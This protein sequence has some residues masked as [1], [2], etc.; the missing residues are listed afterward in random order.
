VV[1]HARFGLVVLG[2]RV[3]DVELAHR[4]HGRAAVLEKLEDFG[5]PLGRD[6]HTLLATAGLLAVAGLAGGGLAVLAGR[7]GRGAGEADS[8]L[9]GGQEFLGARE[10]ERG[11]QAL[12]FVRASGFDFGAERIDLSGQ[13]R[14]LRE[15]VG[16]GGLE[17]DGGGGS[18]GRIHVG[19]GFGLSWSCFLTVH[20]RPYL[21]STVNSFFREKLIIFRGPP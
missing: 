6:G 14:K 10:A 11:V 2:R 7:T 5:L 16:D 21:S 3:G 4:L 8:R 9:V 19:F 1:D 15:L 13:T 12:E 18:R 20:S 17:R